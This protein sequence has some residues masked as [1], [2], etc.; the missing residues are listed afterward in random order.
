MPAGRVCSCEPVLLVALPAVPLPVVTPPDFFWPLMPCVALSCTVLVA[1]F[2][3]LP[4]AA[5]F[6]DGLGDMV[7]CAAAMPEP[8][9]NAAPAKARRFARRS[10]WLAA[11]FSAAAANLQF[12]VEL[13]FALFLLR[14]DNGLRFANIGRGR[15]TMANRR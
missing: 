12:L 9:R 11:I 13:A 3:H 1:A 14:I 7:D 5:G 4:W 15:L 6:V 8:A 2:Q 10:S